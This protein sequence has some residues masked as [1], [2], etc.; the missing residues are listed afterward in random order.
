M[1][2]EIE[3]W[4]D[5][6]N[7]EG[8]YQVSNLGRLKGL[9]R[10]IFRDDYFRVVKGKILTGCI[11]KNGYVTVALSC[12]CITKRFSIHQ[13][14][15]FAFLNHNN[16]S[17]KI[18]V[19]H[20]DG[21]KLNNKLSNLRIVTIREN[22]STCFRKDSIGFTSKYVGVHWNKSSKKWRSCIRINGKLIDFGLFINELDASNAYQN[23]LKTL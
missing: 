9:D 8:I 6:P 14:I 20:I 3:V 22:L 18:N 7:Y 12:N 15:A 1:N 2:E 23:Y 10:K 17:R 5:V 4:K 16:K 11:G 21:N 13:I 19:D